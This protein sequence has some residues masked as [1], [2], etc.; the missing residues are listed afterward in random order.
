MGFCLFC[1]IGFCSE[2]TRSGIDQIEGEHAEN[3]HLYCRSVVNIDM[4][5]CEYGATDKY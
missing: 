4:V 1:L 3:Q 2:K 5:V